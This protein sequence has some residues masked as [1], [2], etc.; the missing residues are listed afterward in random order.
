MTPTRVLC[1]GY[2]SV[3]SE[4][5]SEYVTVTSILHCSADNVVTYFTNYKDMIG[6]KFKKTGHV[7]LTTPFLGWC[8]TLGLDLIQSTCMQNLTISASAVA[9]ISL[10]TSTF[11]LNHVTLTTPLL[12]PSVSTHYEN[13]KGDA[14]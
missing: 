9:D 12:R 3:W 4:I 7:T 6:A 14:K 10:G 11:K 13:T 1:I 5:S 2:Y 8:V